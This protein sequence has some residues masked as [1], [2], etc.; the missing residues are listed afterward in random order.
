MAERDS[1]LVSAINELDDRSFLS[2]CFGPSV[3]IRIWLLKNAESFQ[4]RPSL[5]LT[6]FL[7]FTKD[8]YP[9]VRKAALDGLAGLGITVV[10]DGSMI[11]CCYFRAIE[12]LNDVEDCVRSAAVR[13][14]ITWGLMLA[15][16]S[17]ERKQHFSDEIFANLCSMT[18]DMSMEVRSN[19]FVAIKRLE[20]VS[21]DLL[22]QSM[23]K[24]V[25]SI[26]KG[27]KS[28]V[29]C[30]TEQLEMLALD[31]AGAFVHGVEDEFH[32]V[33]KSA[34]DA[35]FNLI[36]LS[37]KFSGEA[38]S[39][40]MDVLN[41][42]S[43]SVR[44]QALETLH[45]M[46]ISN[47][48]QLQ[49]AHMHM[50]LSAL[51]D[52]NGHVRS[53]LR[54]LLKLAKLPDLGTFQ[55]SFNGLVESL[56][57]YPQDE[58]DVLSVLFHMGQN[59]VNMVAS[60]ITDVFEQ[61]DPAS[62]GKL[63]FDSVKVMAYIVLAI[64][65]PVLDTHSLRIP[66][67]IFSYAATLLGRISHALGDIMDQS[68]IFAYLLQNSKNTGLSDLGFNPEGVPC[69]LTPGSY[70]ND[71]LAI[72]SPKTP[73]M[74]HEKQHKDDDAIESIKTI[75]SKVQDIWPLI[76]SGFLHE[77]LRNLRVF[78]EALEVFTYQIDKYSGALAFTLQYLK[79][80]KLVAKVWNLM[81]SKHSCRIGEWESLLGK[82]EKGLK[83]LRSRFIGFSKEEERHILELM[84]VTSALR[85]ANGEICCHLTIMRKLSMIASNIEHLLKEECIEPSTFVCEVQRSLSKLGAITPKASCYSLDFRKLLKTF[86]LNHLEISKKL[87]HVK[88]ELVIPDNDYEKP[89]Y[90]VP[91]LPVG[92]L[93]QIIL[94]NVSSER[95]L[96]FR[97][98]MD[99]TTSQFIFLDFLPLGG[100]CDEVREFTYTVPFYRTPKASSFIARICIGLECWFESDEVNERRGGPKRDL[101]YICKEKEVYLSMIH[102]S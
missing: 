57:S 66:P 27:K 43:V 32:Q 16:H 81:S 77:I 99:N 49:E 46:A 25:L 21:E 37:T 100:G 79:I 51:S 8:P 62:E 45:H 91:G 88:A 75:L 18:R 74:I 13:V 87:K 11:E 17:P 15:A 83:G 12:L 61:I 64:S 84:L 20:I 69:S 44:L 72:A 94:H 35:L 28:L 9:Y 67:R 36:I 2:L 1:E 48:L 39:L 33:R 24:R 101:A 42:D 53:A 23:S 85:L 7:G 96:W 95:K 63:G 59:H 58:S 92:I 86:T 98:T 38:L 65:A 4:I 78:K 26:F 68:T 14:V 19:A 97:I 93:C 82:L 73:A 10:E 34:C 70:V 22:L 76:Q 3:S 47:C 89:L 56:E 40:L 29:Q 31:V 5:L 71:I 6:V 55:L 90:F 102:N 54:K 80:M 60:I 50:F 30:Y 41:D 52:N